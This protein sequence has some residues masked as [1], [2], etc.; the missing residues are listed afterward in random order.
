MKKL[1]TIMIAFALLTGC[2]NIESSKKQTYRELLEYLYYNHQFPGWGDKAFSE[3]TSID[4]SVYDIDND[5]SDELLIKFDNHTLSVYDHNSDGNIVCQF[6]EDIMSDF[7][8]NGAVRV[9]SAHNQTHSLK[10]HPFTMY[11]YDKENDS[12]NKYGIVY[13]LDKDVVDM[14]NQEKEEVGMTDFLDYPDEYDTSNSGTVYY[15]RPDWDKGAEIPID[16]TE[17]NEQYEQF[18]NGSE[19]LELPF[20]KMTEENIKTVSQ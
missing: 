13:A 3:D 15:I 5:K 10:V 8:E 18:T 1:L 11:R 6:S 4:F 19:I 17:F 20:M 7:Y 9:Y 16:V 14:I 12:Y 2:S